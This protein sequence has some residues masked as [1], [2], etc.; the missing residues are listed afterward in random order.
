MHQH[1]RALDV[2][3]E[4][5]AEPRAFVRAFDQAG[6]V[7]H[8]ERLEVG[9]AHDAE[10]RLERGERIVGDL[11]TRRADDAEQR[12]LPGVRQADHAGVGEQLELQAQLAAFAGLAVVREVRRLARRGREMLVA[13]TAAAALGDAQPLVR[14]AQVGEQPRDALL[15]SA[16]ST[17]RVTSVPTGT[18]ITSSSP[19][20]PDLLFCEPG[21]AGFGRELLLEPEVDQRAQLGIGDQHDVAAA[22]AVAAGRAAF[23]H[24]LLT[25]PRH[26]A[27]AA[28]A[29]R[30]RDARLVDELHQGGE[31]AG[32]SSAKAKRAA[33]TALLGRRRAEPVQTAAG[34]TFTCFRFLELVNVT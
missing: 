3:Q 6:N 26:D 34:T 14:R 5:V 24:V 29:G 16:S 10:L 30:D 2:A 31:A 23:G 12:R 28:V 17:V 9:D 22:P 4:A 8:H 1:A 13:L 33:L 21:L 19:A 20:L 18:R 7:D 11:R 25:P 27:V 15:P 32:S